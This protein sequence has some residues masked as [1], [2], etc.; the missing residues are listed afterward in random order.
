MKTLFETRK[1]QPLARQ[2]LL[3][4]QI[5]SS[6]YDAFKANKMQI[7]VFNDNLDEVY[8]KI[9]DIKCCGIR[10]L[11]W[12]RIISTKEYSILNDVNFEVFGKEKN[13]LELWFSNQLKET[14][15]IYITILGETMDKK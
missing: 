3:R 12:S 9:T 10:Y 14:V 13:Q 7:H 6:H 11:P 1:C 15:T 5:S 8:I 4:F 2:G